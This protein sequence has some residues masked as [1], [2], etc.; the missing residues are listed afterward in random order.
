MYKDFISKVNSSKKKKVVDEFTIMDDKTPFAIRE[1]YKAL[2]TNI[3]Y[4]NTPDKC[5]KI[6]ITSAIPGES[7]TT[8]ATNLALT[9]AENS[10]DKRVLLIKQHL[11]E[12]LKKSIVFLR[13]FLIL[14]KD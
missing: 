13:L 11:I 14:T 4:L 1:A 8:L 2:Y 6:A 10:Q 3:L 5:K 9:I 7:K 12:S